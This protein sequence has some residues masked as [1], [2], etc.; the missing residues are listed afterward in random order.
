MNFLGLIRTRKTQIA[1]EYTV[2]IQ[3]RQADCHILWVDCESPTSLEASY[4]TIAE[5]LQVQGWDDPRTD[6]LE[7]TRKHLNQSYSIKWFM[8]LQNVSRSSLKWE[9]TTGLTTI[10]PSHFPLSLATYLPKP[11]KGQILCISCEAG[12]VQQLPGACTIL[13]IDPLHDTEAAMLFS[14]KVPKEMDT[15]PGIPA[16]TEALDYTPLAIC[17]A[18][19]Y[20]VATRCDSP[21]YLELL[22]SNK[23]YKL[24][25][26]CYK[27]TSISFN[28]IQ[29]QNTR[30]ANLLSLMAVI[31]RRNISKTVLWHAWKYGLS[32]LMN[33]A[34]LPD[35]DSSDKV[36]SP[37]TVADS[38]KADYVEFATALATL[39]AYL[40]VQY[41]ARNETYSLHRI[42]QTAVLSILQQQDT[43]SVWRSSAIVL[44][45]AFSHSCR[46]ANLQV[47]LSNMVLHISEV[48]QEAPIGICAGL[49]K[50][51]ILC[52]MAALKMSLM[53]PKASSPLLQE[54]Y[55]TQ[56]SLLKPQDPRLLRTLLALAE[57]TVYSDSPAAAIPLFVQAIAG[58][59]QTLGPGN[60]KTLFAQVNLCSNYVVIGD[61]D[62]AL[63]VHYETQAAMSASLQISADDRRRLQQRLGELKSLIA[64]AQQRQGRLLK[65][66]SASSEDLQSKN[67]LSVLRQDRKR[68]SVVRAFS[69]SSRVA[70]LDS[71]VEMFEV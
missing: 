29:K 62:A 69:P 42:V 64:L 21:R 51:K 9:T 8:V 32:D 65:T 22:D 71:I 23:S 28:S 57:S 16:L 56:K 13:D 15:S 67:R 46:K 55:Q 58:H 50:A 14:S 17:Q 3:E 26:S 33:Q 2:R 66:K 34:N 12:V 7:K 19:A 27:T 24:S 49:A 41:D 4:R 37:D 11:P 59:K 52:D 60:R 30:A 25:E 70:S 38:D 6:I 1:A 39:E 18:A 61:V 5:T 47:S 44:L 10:D 63:P 48:V 35:L 36:A 68:V 20:I 31:Y 53:Q 45:S 43:I 40:L 54:A